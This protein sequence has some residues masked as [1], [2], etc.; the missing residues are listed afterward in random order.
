MGVHFEHAGE[1]S[2]DPAWFRC[3]HHFT[4]M[5]NFGDTRRRVGAN[6]RSCSISKTFCYHHKIHRRVQIPSLSLVLPLYNKLL[7]HLKRW[8]TE[9]T[10]S[11]E[12]RQGA[13]A[14]TL[15]IKKYYT[16]LTEVYLVSTV[17]D[18][19]LKVGYF[20]DSLRW[21]TDAGDNQ[22]VDM[23]KEFVMPA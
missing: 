5:E 16:R 18:C 20:E 8:S 13:E 17:L 23:V 2:G 10:H 4:R 14:A 11:I 3:H 12:S 1:G 21:E 9:E 7:A 15:K 6:F 22:D 19:R